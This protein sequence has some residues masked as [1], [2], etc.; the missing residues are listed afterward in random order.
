VV[1]GNVVVAGRMLG[2]VIDQMVNKANSTLVP[3][4]RKIFLY[5]GH[6]NNVINILAA[7]NLFQPHVPKYTASAIVEL[8]WIAELQSHGVKVKD[9]GVASRFCIVV[10]GVVPEGRGQ[11]PRSAEVGGVRYT[12]PSKRLYTNYRTPRSC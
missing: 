4:E 3:L 6:E 10:S 9:W 11:H 12:L 1:L 7:L 5:S 8:H 2:K